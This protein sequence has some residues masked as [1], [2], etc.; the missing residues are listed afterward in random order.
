MIEFFEKAVVEN[1]FKH[2]EKDPDRIDDMFKF[3]WNT[4][5]KIS[6]FY[7]AA[8]GGLLSFYATHLRDSMDKLWMIPL[9]CVALSG[10]LGLFIAALSIYVFQFYDLAGEVVGYE[11][12]TSFFYL[13]I[14]PLWFFV[15]II[16]LLC[17][18]VICACGMLFIPN[19]VLNVIWCFMIF[20]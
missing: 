16:F 17:L 9:F 20:V 15:A 4:A 10:L 12:L 5:L 7:V 18:L 2:L 6:G 14:Y 11:G 13:K 8:I 3:Y 19:I 1:I